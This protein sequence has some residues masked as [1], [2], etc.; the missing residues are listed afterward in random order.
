M[1]LLDLQLPG[2][3]AWLRFATGLM[4]GCWIGVAIGFALALFFAGRR[5]RQLETANL[6]LRVKIRAR[7]RAQARR[8]GAPG[9]VLV[10]TPS[11]TVSRPAG[12]RFASGGR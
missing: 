10:A 9:P 4:V 2:L 12:S 5:I 1:A 7:E 11:G 6:L 3:H 8:A